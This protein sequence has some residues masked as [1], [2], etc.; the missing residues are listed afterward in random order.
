MNQAEV[1]S[2]TTV[3]NIFF[4]GGGLFYFLC[5]GIFGFSCVL[6]NCKYNQLNIGMCGRFVLC[7]EQQYNLMPVLNELAISR[8][9]EAQAPL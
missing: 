3:G 7:S 5:S 4:W 8:G 6:G 9:L 2:V 1:P